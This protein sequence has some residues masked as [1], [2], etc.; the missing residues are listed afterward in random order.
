MRIGNPFN[1]Y[2]VGAFAHDF[3]NSFE[4]ACQ[5]LLLIH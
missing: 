3:D 5:F 4:D 2:L 1:F